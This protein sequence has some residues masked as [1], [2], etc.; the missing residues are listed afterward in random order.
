MKITRRQLRAL[1][2]ESCNF[3]NEELEKEKNKKEV[4]KKIKQTFDS[5]KFFKTLIKTGNLEF[6]VGVDKKLKL[7]GNPMDGDVA[8]KLTGSKGKGKLFLK[9]NASD[10]FTPEKLDVM[11]KVGMRI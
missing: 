3:I 9:G 1:I 10:I 4:K 8:F 7:T 5:E 2:R 11:F 6:P